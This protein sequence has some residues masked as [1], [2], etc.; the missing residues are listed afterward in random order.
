MGV[1]ISGGRGGEDTP[2]PKIPAYLSVLALTG[3]RKLSKSTGNL[4]GFLAEDYSQLKWPLPKAFGQEKYGFSLIDIEDPRFLKECAGMSKKLCRL[5]YDQQIIDLE[6]RNTYKK[7]LDAEHRKG[8]LPENVNPKTKTILEKEVAEHLKYLHELQHQKD[9][10]QQEIQ[11]TYQR[12][13]DIKAR[14]KKEND[15]EDLRLMM[16]KRELEKNGRESPVWKVKF[17]VRSQHLNNQASL[18]VSLGH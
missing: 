11:E 2:I 8:T 4:H 14:I 7:L 18:G 12:C 3:K 13:A 16:E 9:M 15:L 17:N 6:W 10:Y 5:S 1:A